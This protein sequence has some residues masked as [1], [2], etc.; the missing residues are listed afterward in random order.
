MLVIGSMALISAIPFA[1][2]RPVSDMDVM[3]SFEEF[4]AARDNYPR[5]TEQCF[6]IN[7]GK[8][9]V[10]KFDCGLVLE[11]EITWDGSLA[12][13]LH[14][15]VL[16]EKDTSGD[17]APLDVLYMLKLSHRYLKNSP[18][19]LK[20]VGDIQTMRQ[21]GA[22]FPERYRDW[23]NRRVEATYAYGHP[24]LNQDK[25]SFFDTPG[26]TYTY[27]HDDIHKVVA[28][29]DAPAYTLFIA[30]GAQVKCDHEKFVNLPHQLKLNAV[31]EESLVLAIERSQVP[32]AYRED[33]EVSFLMALEK[34]CTSITSG[35]FR[36]FAWEN[37]YVVREM[38]SGDYVD[39]FALAVEE[40][41]VGLF[42]TT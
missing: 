39:A 24:N 2:S 32:S 14:D 33:P 18:H 15:R 9:W 29:G 37:Y 31:Y 40:G 27:D 17:N 41:R 25:G 7:E 36:E 35:W 42:E 13:E 4:T 19:F 1:T 21:A 3:C 11:A 5:K 12:K 23:Y 28:L 22:K 34:V 20:T 38:Y 30:E 6:P 26:V 10:A 8:K 16:A